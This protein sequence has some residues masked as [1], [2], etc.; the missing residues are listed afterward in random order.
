MKDKY[1]ITD[2]GFNQE[3]RAVVRELGMKVARNEL[4]SLDKNP[5][6]S[7]E[8]GMRCYEVGSATA[9]VK[10]VVEAEKWCAINAYDADKGVCDEHSIDDCRGRVCSAQE[11]LDYLKQYIQVIEE[12]TK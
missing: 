4:L 5:N 1:H 6:F 10:C 12:H 8:F 9:W 2:E 3:T 7:E 11:L